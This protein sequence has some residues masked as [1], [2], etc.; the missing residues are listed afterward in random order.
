MKKLLFGVLFIAMVASMIGAGTWAY[1]TDY[2]FSAGNLFQG[3]VMDLKIDGVDDPLGAYFTLDC[4]APCDFDEVVVEY[5]NVGC[6]DGY[7]DLMFT[8][9]SAWENGLMEPEIDAGDTTTGQWGG[10]LCKKTLI[11]VTVNSNP[12]VDAT[13]ETPIIAG[14]S[15]NDLQNDNLDLKTLITAGSETGVGTGANRADVKIKWEVPCETGNEIM[16]DQCNVDVRFSLHQE[17]FETIEH[18]LRVTSNGCCPID[19]SGWVSGTV[20]AGSY[21]DFVVTEG[22]TVVLSADDSD[23]C[24]DF[25]DWTGNVTNTGNPNTSIVVDTDEEVIANCVAATYD[26]TVDQSAQ[27]CPVDVGAPVSA[28]VAAGTSETFYDLTCLAQISVDADDSGPGCIFDEWAGDID[29]SVDTDPN[30]VTMDADKTVTAQCITENIALTVASNGCCPIDVGTPVNDTVAAGTSETFFIAGGLDVSVSADDSDECCVFDSWSDAGA[31]T[32]DVYIDVAKTVT[33]NCHTIL[34]SL[35]VNALDC[36][37]VDVGAPVNTR[38]S[39]GTSDTFPLDCCTTVSI[40]A[41]PSDVQC[42]VFDNWSG[43]VTGS[44]NP[45][46][47]H[48]DADGATV[49]ANC[50]WLDSDLY[51]NS[52]GCCFVEVYEDAQLVYTLNPGESWS[53][54]DVLCCTDVDVVAVPPPPS[55]VCNDIELDG[56]SQGCLTASVH[57]DG[58]DHT[59]DVYCEVDIVPQPCCWCIYSSEWWTMPAQ[60]PDPTTTTEY[61]CLHTV[62]LLPAGHTENLPTGPYTIADPTFHQEFVGY[63]GPVP[64]GYGVPEWHPLNTKIPPMPQPGANR[65]NSILGNVYA[66][67]MAYWN[68]QL[69][70]INWKTRFNVITTLGPITLYSVVLMVNPVA[71]TPGWPYAPG[72]AWLS[73]GFSSITMPSWTYTE[74]SGMQMVDCGAN[75]PPTLCNIVD[76]YAWGDADGIDDDGDGTFDEDPG[77]PMG[78]GMDDDADGLID[79]DGGD[80]VFDPVNQRNELTISS[81]SYN[82]NDYACTLEKWTYPG[83]LYYGFEHL[84][85]LWYCADP[86]YPV[87]EPEIPQYP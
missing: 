9:T 36:C 83:A 23:V 73:L 14:T 22:K 69:D 6:V 29:L 25:V 67:G 34:S 5:R 57:M 27:C 41:V 44:V 35:T 80:G 78:N 10:E 17:P 40:T 64:N 13:F 62:E 4:I 42:C 2:E 19:V 11:T 71:G 82:S 70:L 18:D 85:L 52:I 16:S 33:A 28:T 3:G 84:C 56:V 49:T 74:V 68:S 48:I 39:A 87:E 76:A 81:T 7:A 72:E 45:E 8:I 51:V 37:H 26:L 38:V 77:G 43:D 20:S 47:I 12:W 55:C 31:Q 46:S 30:Q 65:F 50:H 79:E 63:A 60:P 1:F 54:L 66:T 75:I 58:Q 15:L 61:F 21:Q 24:C 32:H 59:F 53:D 86:P